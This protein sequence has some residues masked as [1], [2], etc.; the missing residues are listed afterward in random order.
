M[1]ENKSFQTTRSTG[2]IAMKTIYKTR[3]S[4]PYKEVLSNK[5]LLLVVGGL[6]LFAGVSMLRTKPRSNK[7]Y[8]DHAIDRRNPFNMFAAGIF[9][10]RR[11]IDKSGERPLFERR[12]SAY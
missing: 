6:A 2:C 12:Q 3:A 9:P 10:L 7:R 1:A 8:A 5:P 4:L 11:T